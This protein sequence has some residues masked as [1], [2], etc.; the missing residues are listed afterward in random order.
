MAP[1]VDSKRSKDGA[2]ATDHHGKRT[3]RRAVGAAANRRIQQRHSPCGTDLVQ[4][5]HNRGGV[6]GKI[7]Y[8]RTA[9]GARED[10][11]LPRYYRLYVPGNGEA[12]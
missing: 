1:R 10:P 2:V 12:G 5:P 8:D 6:G 7:E 9:T 4:V 11:V 3:R